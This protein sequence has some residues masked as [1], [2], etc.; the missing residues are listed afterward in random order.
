MIA[1]ANVWV[2]DDMSECVSDD[3]CYKWM[4][5]WTNVWVILCANT[6]CEWVRAGAHVNVWVHG[7]LFCDLKSEWMLT[8]ILFN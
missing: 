1:C 7:Q 8:I 3:V 2:G 6:M 4:R 5:V